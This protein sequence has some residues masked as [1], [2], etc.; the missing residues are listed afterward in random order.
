MLSSFTVFQTIALWASIIDFQGLEYDT[1]P[2]LFQLTIQI[3]LLTRNA[4][5]I[6]YLV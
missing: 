4:I 3:V 2:P 6:F 5:V 1:L